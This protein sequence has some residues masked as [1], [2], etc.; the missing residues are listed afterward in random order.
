MN[1]RDEETTINRDEVDRFAMI[2]DWW[3]PQ[4][5]NA[6][7]LHSMNHLRVPLIKEALL[8]RSLATSHDNATAPLEGYTILDVGC[9]AGLLCEVG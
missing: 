8:K 7:G 2:N 3:D 9:G 5:G 1:S 4:G 6:K